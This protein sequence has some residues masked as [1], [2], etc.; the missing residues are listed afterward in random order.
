MIEGG[1][2]EGGKGGEGRLAAA[3]CSYQPALL[4]QPATDM[5]Y[6]GRGE[7]GGEGCMAKLWVPYRGATWVASANPYLPTPCGTS[8]LAARA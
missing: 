5:L 8:K 6:Q 3:A 7:E 1:R 4:G 2:G